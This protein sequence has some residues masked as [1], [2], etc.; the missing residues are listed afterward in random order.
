MILLS[1]PSVFVAKVVSAFYINERKM[2]SSVGVSAFA[3]VGYQIFGGKRF[4]CF[5]TAAERKICF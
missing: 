1:E 3:N 4:H 5:M 2:H